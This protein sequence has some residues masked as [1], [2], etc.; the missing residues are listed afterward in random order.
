MTKED[1]IGI[2]REIESTRDKMSASQA[3]HII[4]GISPAPLTAKKLKIGD[5][6]IANAGVK[7][8]PYVI[9]SI[10]R[11]L[12]VCI[13]M[14]S[15]KHALVMCRAYPRV[16]NIEGDEYFSASLTAFPVTSIINNWVGVY[17]NASHLRSVKRQVSKLLKL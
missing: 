3:R 16:S 1:A 4:E 17:D 9:L 12:A 6:V 7:T 15:S 2:I 5:I 10:R 8:R 14:T 11:G 13:S